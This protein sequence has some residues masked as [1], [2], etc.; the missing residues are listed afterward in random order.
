MKDV[1]NPDREDILEWIDS[2]TDGWPDS[3]W[4]LYVLSEENDLLI[5][6]LANKLTSSKRDFFIHVLYYMVGEYMSDNRNVK[7]RSRIDRLLGLVDEK[8]TKEVQEWKGKTIEL[9]QGKLKYESAFWFNYMFY[10][11]MK[12]YKDVDEDDWGL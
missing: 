1:Y 4:D 11:D 6:E 10:E 3:D 8:A 2:K 7:K 9:F 5:F 12:K